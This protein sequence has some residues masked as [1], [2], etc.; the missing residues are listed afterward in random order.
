VKFCAATSLGLTYRAGKFALRHRA[1]VAVFAIFT[2]LALAGIAA[3]GR[4]SRAAV[5]MANR[6]LSD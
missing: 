3:I 5:E 4:E 2:G 6:T 1:G